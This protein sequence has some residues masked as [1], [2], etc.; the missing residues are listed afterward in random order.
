MPEGEGEGAKLSIVDVKSERKQLYN[1]SRSFYSV[2]TSEYLCPTGF[3][4]FIE[5]NTLKP[6]RAVPNF[7][8]IYYSADELL[9]VG[10]EF[11]WNECV[12]IISGGK[13]ADDWD[14]PILIIKC[15]GFVCTLI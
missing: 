1:S 11:D 4:N 13:E 6:N 5:V 8:I 7:L 10:N 3:P 14:G 2:N 12:N 9:P 15:Q